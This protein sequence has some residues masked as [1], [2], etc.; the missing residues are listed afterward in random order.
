MLRLTPPSDILCLT[1]RLYES[2]VEQPA[3]L[4]YKSRLYSNTNMEA[5]A[6]SL[7]DP[8]KINFPQEQLFY[9]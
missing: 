3:F 8:Y 7:S 9:V 5:Q 4:L 2:S 6:S 1:F